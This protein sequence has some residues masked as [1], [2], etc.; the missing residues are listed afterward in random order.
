MRSERVAFY[1][2]LNLMSY[3]QNLS[4]IEELGYDPELDDL[5]NSYESFS[6]SF[7]DI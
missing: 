4:F 5:E 2:P 7:S 6:F 1:L 3:E